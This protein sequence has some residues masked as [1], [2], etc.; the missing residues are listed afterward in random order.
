MPS[1]LPAPYSNI[2]L[3]EGIAANSLDDDY[4]EIRPV[5]S[6]HPGG[7][8][9]ITA[10]GLALFA[11]LVTIA[12]AQNRTD[13]PAD[14]VE[15]NTLIANIHNRKAAIEKGESQARKIR[16]DVAKLRALSSRTDPEFEALRVIASDIS[17]TGPGVVV[18]ADNSTKQNSGGRV[19]DI[20]LQ[21]LVNGLWYAGAEAISINGSRL[22]TL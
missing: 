18:T 16:S 15:L 8:T 20:D 11:L 4:Y 3:L 12:S 1:R 14:Q 13:R 21:L 10:I 9:L 22:G 17:V 19:T 5:N 7:G 6:K 2:G